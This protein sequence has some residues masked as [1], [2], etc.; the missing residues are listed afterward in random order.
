MNTIIKAR[1]L[2]VDGEGML[3]YKNGSLIY[4]TKSG[5]QK[6]KIGNKYNR[7]KIL[8]RLARKEPRCAA[9]IDDDHILVSFEGNILN[10]CISKNIITLEH[11][12]SKGMNNP[13]EFLIMDDPVSGEKKVFYGE[14]IWNDT[15]GPVDIYRRKKGVWESVHTFPDNSITHIHNLVFDEHK[16]GFFILTG[17][18]DSE[19]GIWFADYNFKSVKPV[20]VG[21]QQ[22]RACVAFPDEHGL[23]YATDTPLENNYIYRVELDADMNVVNHK[24]VYDMPG[25]CIYGCRHNGDMF[26]STSVEPDSSLSTWRYRLTYKLGA[27]VRDRNTHIIKGSNNGKFEEIWQ[28][29]KDL[30]PIWLFQFGNVLFPKNDSKELYMVLQSTVKGHGVTVKITD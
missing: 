29:K 24:R 18:E 20:L 19:S 26:F 10:Y 3:S 23:Y 30:L 8:E 15:K 25:P 13:L 17:D 16:N 9:K 14:Y 21:S 5:N 11:K 7:I 27:G 1:V 6:C 22:Y 28:F 4:Q 2:H 12:Y